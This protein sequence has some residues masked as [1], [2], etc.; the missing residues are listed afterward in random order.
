MQCIRAWDQEKR[1]RFLQFVTG[2]CR[3]P[4]GGF[5]NLQGKERQHMCM[6][7]AQNGTA[8]LLHSVELLS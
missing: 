8:S 2:T 6:E 4:M 7:C 3:V 5:R 1:V